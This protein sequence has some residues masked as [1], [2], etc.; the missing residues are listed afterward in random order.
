MSEYETI[1]E[2]LY[3]LTSIQANIVEAIVLIGHEGH[4]LTRETRGNIGVIQQGVSDAGECLT[5]IEDIVTQ[6]ANCPKRNAANDMYEA[7]VGLLKIH[8][9]NCRLDHNDFCQQHMS[10]LP[11]RVAVAQAA[12]KKAQDKQSVS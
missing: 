10:S 1:I 11:C 7:L 9:P 5:A 6:L 3:K 2:N 8:E 12:L 4:L